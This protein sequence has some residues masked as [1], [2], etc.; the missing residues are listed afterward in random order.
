M[1][2][3]GIDP[4][5]SRTGVCCLDKD[6]VDVTSITVPRKLSVFERQMA[7]VRR[8]CGLLKKGDVV[9]LEEFGVS[10]RFAPSGRFVER[11][12]ICGMLKVYIPAITGMMWFSVPPNL[13]KSFVAGKASARKTDVVD[14]VRNSWKVDVH[15]DDEADAFGLAKYVKVVVENDIKHKQKVEKFLQ[16]PGNRC[17]LASV[18][19]LTS[20][21]TS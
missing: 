4:S 9:A 11:I 6:N 13:L 5:L 7:M 10:A 15:N 19:F 16:F 21:L 18:R 17:A 1:R 20:P 14:C 12:E 3:I 8:V 2:F